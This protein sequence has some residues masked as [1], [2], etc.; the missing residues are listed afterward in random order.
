MSPL[1][2]EPRPWQICVGSVA[3][4][5]VWDSLL[6]GDPHHAGTQTSMTGE[7]GSTRVQETGLG[8]SKLGNKF[9]GYCTGSH[10]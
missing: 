9:P 8:V 6:G 2:L 5:G 10:R 7:G 3:L 1:P 4:A